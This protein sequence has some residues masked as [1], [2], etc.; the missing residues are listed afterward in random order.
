[1]IRF[2]RLTPA[3]LDAWLV[4]QQ[5]PGNHARYRLRL[6]RDHAGQLPA[7]RDELRAYIDEAFEDAR[8]RLRKGLEDSLSRATS[9]CG[10]SRRR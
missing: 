3:S 2:R 5:L 9:Q 6:W 7:M 10:A 1:M 4:D 8:L